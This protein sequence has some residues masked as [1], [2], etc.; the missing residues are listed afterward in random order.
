[1]ALNCNCNFLVTR[2]SDRTKHFVGARLATARNA[3]LAEPDSP[4]STRYHC[5]PRRAANENITEP[6]NPVVFADPVLKLPYSGCS[7]KRNP[8]PPDSTPTV[9]PAAVTAAPTSEFVNVMPECQRASAARIKPGR[10]CVAEH[11]A[12]RA[13]E[14]CRVGARELS[15]PSRRCRP[16]DIARRQLRR[17]HA[18]SS[19]QSRI[20]RAR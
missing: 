9:T 4:I 19:N 13:F 17:S 20:S 15:C 11:A 12:D 16:S 7:A 1:M 6:P 14:I 3:P 8:P 5:T 18:S 10:F 2:T